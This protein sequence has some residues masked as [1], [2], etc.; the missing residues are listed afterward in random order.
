MDK[1]ALDA[2]LAVLHGNRTRWARLPIAE[3]LGYLEAFIEGTAQAAEAQVRVAMAAKGTAAG[4]AGEAEDWL[5]GPVVQIRTARLLLESLRAVAR[6]GS[7]DVADADVSVR[8]DGRTVLRIFPRNLLDRLT[9]SGFVADAWM[10]RGVTPANLRSHM[11]GFYRQTDP[12]GAVALVLGAGNVASIGPLD[13]VHK[14]FQ[15]GQV[16]MLKLN[17]VN[18]YLAPFVAQAFAPLIRDGFVRMADGGADVGDYLCKHPQVEEIHITGS[19]RTHDAIVYGVG[20]EGAANKA[21]D[22]PINPRRVTSELGNVS[23]VIVVPGPWTQA[24]LRFHAENVATQM[25]NNGGFNCN[26]AKVIVLP[27]EWPEKRAFLDTLRSVLAALPQRRAYYP[28]AEQRYDHFVAAYPQAQPVGQRVP[29]VLPWTLI[30]GVPA[31]DADA[32][33][34]REESFCGITA[35]TELPGHSAAEFLHH[36]VTLCNERL[37][38]S[39]NACL[40][41]HPRTEEELGGALDAA[42]DAL[43]Y[44]TV[45]IN[46]WAA[47]G[48]GMGVTPWG[49]PPGHPRTDIQ[50]GVGFV[51]NALMLDRPQKTVIRGPF[52]VRPRPPWFV[53]HKNAAKVA[54]RLVALE[55][56]PGLWHLPG[57]IL[58]AARG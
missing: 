29:G 30:P 8:P 41:V 45:V 43:R 53:T 1:A 11:A 4:T 18:A 42:I 21:A 37:W 58:D 23:P 55:R 13:V 10:E 57:L 20:A 2:D 28:G 40:L 50:S 52:R 39:L 44:G 27:A 15:E 7:P 56:R 19:D 38:G 35:V 32:V 31:D 24:D 47:L 12:V 3:K 34:F 49:A 46:H 51:H 26:A 17:P 14:L 48:Y 54:R 5:G 16:C 33:A 36:A 25:T 6:T 9:F 22:T